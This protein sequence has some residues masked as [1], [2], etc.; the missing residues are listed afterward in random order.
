L[1]SLQRKR[2]FEAIDLLVITNSSPGRARQVAIF[3]TNSQL[4]LLLAY[5]SCMYQYVFLLDPN[6]K[7]FLIIVSALVIPAAY[8]LS[9]G[10]GDNDKSE[11]IHDFCFLFTGKLRRCAGIGIHISRDL[12]IPLGCIRYLSHLPGS[13]R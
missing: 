13:S 4:T 11:N 8:H 3:L 6:K 7:L 12:D 1:Q 10:G 5:D 2:T 9:L